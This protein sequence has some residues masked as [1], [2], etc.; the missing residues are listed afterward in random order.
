MSISCNCCWGSTAAFS[1]CG[2]ALWGNADDGGLY[3]CVTSSVSNFKDCWVVDG[4]SYYIYSWPNSYLD[5]YIY[6]FFCQHIQSKVMG[7]NTS[8]KFLSVCNFASCDIIVSVCINLKV[9]EVLV[10]QFIKRTFSR[11]K[12]NRIADQVS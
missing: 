12:E 1:F 6:K 9:Y 3:I 7:E 4:E 5:E 2:S 11:R 10:D 8:I